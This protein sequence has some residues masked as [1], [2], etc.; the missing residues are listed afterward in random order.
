MSSGLFGINAIII[1]VPGLDEDV[2]SEAEVVTSE[3]EVVTSEAEVVTFIGEVVT[4]GVEVVTF[5]GEVVISNSGEVSVFS[6][7]A[8]SSSVNVGGNVTFAEPTT[9][10]I[11]FTTSSAVGSEGSVAILLNGSIMS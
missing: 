4:F 7:D 10:S 6:G 5:S 8:D 1:V 9:F 3:A 2:T 11:I